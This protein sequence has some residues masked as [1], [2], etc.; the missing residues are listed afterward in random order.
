M[1]VAQSKACQCLCGPRLF[2]GMFHVL[3]S[4]DLFCESHFFLFH[5]GLNQ[6]SV[7]LCHVKGR[8]KYFACRIDSI[9]LVRIL[10][11]DAANIYCSKS[12]LDFSTG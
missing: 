5:V 1:S 7:N 3:K 12:E 2:L 11:W 9:E 10:M 8:E 4:N 6:H